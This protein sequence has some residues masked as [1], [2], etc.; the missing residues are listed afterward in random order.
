MVDWGILDWCAVIAM[1]IAAAI[2]AVDTG[3]KQTPAL[4]PKIEPLG[5]N[6]VWG[7]APL[8]LLIFG[9]TIFAKDALFSSSRLAQQDDQKKSAPEVLSST[10]N[11][12][13]QEKP[14]KDTGEVSL[15][16]PLVNIPDDL[17]EVANDDLRSYAY[18]LNDEV[19]SLSMSYN[20]KLKYAG[21]SDID[22]ATPKERSL[23]ERAEYVMKLDQSFNRIFRQNFEK[24]ALRLRAELR[25][26]LRK[27][28]SFDYP[29]DAGL[30]SPGNADN[31]ADQISDWAKELP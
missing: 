27:D 21:Y 11:I 2:L 23:A 22:S 19:R 9:L 6:K 18:Q 16:S 5:T 1:V 14:S 24:D 30:I 28:A 25:R 10:S 12:S 17:K 3:M 20:N 7:F 26:R 4:K 8:I 31:V 13:T 15:Q 29:L